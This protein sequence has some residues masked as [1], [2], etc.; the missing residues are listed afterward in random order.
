MCF[1][2][3]TA[4]TKANGHGVSVEVGYTMDRAI[5]QA[6]VYSIKDCKE[7]EESLRDRPRQDEVPKGLLEDPQGR[8]GVRHKLPQSGIHAK[9]AGRGVGRYR[10]DAE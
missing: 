6:V 4:N 7:N 5:G 1:A 2:V 3:R 8:T 10:G 9:H